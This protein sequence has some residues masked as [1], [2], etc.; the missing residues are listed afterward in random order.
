MN[1][2]AA[3]LPPN[4]DPRLLTEAFRRARSRADNALIDSDLLI[5]AIVEEAR[6]G[7]RD[8]YSLVKASGAGRQDAVA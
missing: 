2:T 5:S 3:H 4:I 7:A 8:I 6:R 1:L